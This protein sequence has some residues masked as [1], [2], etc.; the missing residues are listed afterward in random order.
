[1]EKEEQEKLK[2]KKI[3]LMGLGILGGGEALAKFLIGQKT[4]LTITDLKNKN[5]LKYVLKKFKD[6]KIKFIL[7]KH[8][9]IDFKNNN[10]IVFNPAVSI[11]SPWVKV[12][13]KYKKSIENDLTLFLKFLAIKKPETDYIVV[14]GTRGKTTVATWIN[15]FL[16]KSILGGNMP[17]RGLFKIIKKKTRLFILEISSFQL[18]FMRNNLKSPK[19]AVINNIYIDHINRH[20]TLK[21]YIKEKSKIFLNQTKHDFLVLN[22]DNKY[23]RYFLKYRPKSR[24]Y[25]FSLKSL[26][27]NKNGLFLVNSNIFFQENGKK[28]FICSAPNLANHQKSNLL[29]SLLGS[30]L[31][32]QNWQELVKKIINLSSV[33]FRQEFVFKDKNFKIIND[34]AAT[35]PDGAMAAIDRFKKNKKE[36]ILIVGGTDKMLEFKELADKIKKYIKRDNLFLL[37]G[38]AT[39]KLIVELKKIKYFKKEYKPNAFEDLKDILINIKENFKNGIVLF[40]PASASFEKFKNEFDRGEKFNRLVKSIFIK[41]YGK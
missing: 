22:A 4:K 38:S 28:K 41:N 7:G 30:Y 3:L 31:Y 15:Y 40:S 10:I 9:E 25:Y 21:N 36:L 34:T 17:S 33:P 35:S 11:F 26:Q 8:R 23:S 39:Q 20:R 19:I 13:K 18:E 2:N 12:A 37:N 24:I 1:M 27:K 29:S 14:T 6:Q 5:E 16:E 32:K